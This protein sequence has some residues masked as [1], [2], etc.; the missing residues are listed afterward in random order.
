MAT[1]GR[2]DN[3]NDDGAPPT[4]L[5]GLV[6]RSEFLAANAGTRVPMPAFVLL[7]R[8]RGDATAA[9]G[10]GLTATRKLGG[11]VVRNRAKRRLRHAI[12]AVFPHGA[13]AG[14]DYV[15]IARDGALALPWPRLTADLA[16]ALGKARKRAADPHYVPAP[17][18]SPRR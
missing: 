6:K 4:P 15:L 7:R 13:E 16:A 18:R 9:V 2:L 3:A 8:D 5:R 11:A 10:F 1:P 14:C 17:R 12:A